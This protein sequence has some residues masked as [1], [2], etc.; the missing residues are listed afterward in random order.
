MD[1]FFRNSKNKNKPNEDGPIH[2]SNIDNEYDEDASQALG[3]NDTCEITFHVHMPNWFDRSLQPLVLGSV[4]ELGTWYYPV[5]KLRQSDTNSTYWFSDPVKIRIRDHP[6]YYKYAFYQPK[7]EQGVFDILGDRVLGDRTIVMEGN[8]EYDNRSLSY[9]GFQYDVWKTNHAKKLFSPDLKKDYKFVDVVYESLTLENIKE[10]IMEFQ[11]LLKYQPSLTADAVDMALIRNLVASSREDY[12]RIFV[13]FLL[14]YYIKVAQERMGHHQRVR[15]PENFPSINLLQALEKIRSED[16]PS[17]ARTLFTLAT[18]A[19]VR[20]NSSKRNVFDWMKMF[21]IAPVVDPSYTFLV[22]I[23]KH[24][25]DQR[26]QVSIFYNSLKRNVKPYLDRIDRPQIYQTAI[27]KI[28]EISFFDVESC[29]FLVHE[30]IGK[31]KMD[32]RIKRSIDKFISQYID[33]DDP[34]NLEQHFKSLSEDLRVECAPVFREQ[35][36]KLLSNN[37]IS[38][39]SEYSQPMFHLFSQ[40]F[41]AESDIMQA[42]VL[43]SK[44]RNFDLLLSFPKWSKFTLESRNV[45]ADFKAKITALCEEWYST[46]ISAVTNQKNTINP[47]IFFYQQLSAISFVLQRRTDIYKKLV[48]TVEQKVLNFPQEWLFKATSFVGALESRIVGDFEKVLRQKLKSPLSSD[49]NDDAV[50]KIISQICN[51]SGSPLY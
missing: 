11:A 27:E 4:R 47:V 42:L 18:S 38:W 13:C 10:K 43:L 1:W 9:G 35:F 34:R 21:A 31:E 12:Q 32:E 7:K 8:S 3:V 26:N 50:I 23:E 41:T 5:V 6:I 14:A 15:L 36:S 16:I 39:K 2:K 29:D 44:S 48:D 51:S 49:T 24:N 37:R 33:S 46:I 30:M 25:Y 17:D 28:I 40:L 45:K 20:H 22:N 19:L